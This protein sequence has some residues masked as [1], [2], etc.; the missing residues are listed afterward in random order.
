MCVRVC[1]RSA[2]IVND[3]RK[4]Q[5]Q[6]LTNATLS[7]EFSVH[8][9]STY[10]MFECTKSERTEIHTDTD[11]YIKT[12]SRTCGQRCRPSTNGLHGN[13]LYATL[14]SPD[15]ASLASLS[16]S[17]R[18]H[19]WCHIRRCR[20]RRNVCVLSPWGSIYCAT[21]THTQTMVEVVQNEWCNTWC[22]WP[23]ECIREHA[24]LLRC[25]CVNV[26][27]RTVAEWKTGIVSQWETFNDYEKFANVCIFFFTQKCW[28]SY[29]AIRREEGKRHSNVFMAEYISL[30]TSKIELHLIQQTWF[31]QQLWW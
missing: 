12:I 23:P 15:N 28:L 18:D 6:P 25:E 31:G 22:W 10:G 19:F 24:M 21:H 8:A 17:I 14:F 1:S 26:H 9:F 13:S 20:C 5:P 27:T 2:F 11:T 16:L 29:F 4:P 30:T 3:A 7:G